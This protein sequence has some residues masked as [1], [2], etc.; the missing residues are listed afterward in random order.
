MTDDQKDPISSTVLSGP[1]GFIF[2]KEEFSVAITDD[3][4][5]IV[6][7][8]DGRYKKGQRYVFKEAGV[9]WYN[10]GDENVKFTNMDDPAPYS[11]I[12]DKHNFDDGGGK[13]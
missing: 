7:L 4:F 8:P 3:G 6:Y 11:I 1:V 9:H 2:G 10:Q 12:Y 5:D 13:R